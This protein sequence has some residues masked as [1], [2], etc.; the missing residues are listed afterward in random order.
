MNFQKWST[1]FLF[2]LMIILNNGCI[3]L[4]GLETGKSL[5]KNNAEIGFS[6]NMGTTN[7]EIIDFGNHNIPYAGPY[8]ETGASYGILENLDVGLHIGSTLN[9][10]FDLKYQLLGDKYSMFALAIGSG[11]DRIYVNQ[12]P[13]NFPYDQKATYNFQFPLFASL[14]SKDGLWH[15][16]LSPRYIRQFGVNKKYSSAADYF[17]ANTGILFGRKVQFGLD[18]GY[19]GVQNATQQGSILHLSLGMKFFVDDLFTKK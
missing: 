6:I 15:G 3:S 19:Y 9:L 13:D 18:I 7:E 11:F 12:K 8:I 1:I 17:G 4:S 16:Y 5:G 10:G 14:H 2:S